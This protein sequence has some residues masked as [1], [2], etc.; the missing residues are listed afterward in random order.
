[1]LELWIFE[2]VLIPETFQTLEATHTIFEADPMKPFMG[3]KHP[4]LSSGN[5]H[6]IRR[7]KAN[8]AFHTVRVWH[9]Y[10]SSLA[11]LCLQLVSNMVRVLPIIPQRCHLL[12]NWASL[13]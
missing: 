11:V 9:I 6:A 4:H 7:S 1:M 2:A 8:R 5:R 3:E 13:P 10:F 12:D